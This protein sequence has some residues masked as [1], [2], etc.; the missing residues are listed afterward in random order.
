MTSKQLPVADQCPCC[1]S[2]NQSEQLASV[3]GTDKRPVWIKQRWEPVR[4]D[5]VLS[6]WYW[7]HGL[8]CVVFSLSCC[9]FDV[10][11][12]TF[13]RCDST[14]FVL[15][16]TNTVKP[17]YSCAKWH[18][19]LEEVFSSSTSI[20]LRK[21]WT[22]GKST[23]FLRILKVKYLNWSLHSVYFTIPSKVTLGL[24]RQR[25]IA[26]Q[27]LLIILELLMKSCIPKDVYLCLVPWR[28]RREVIKKFSEFK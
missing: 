23:N 26:S 13:R 14:Q 20:R 8:I 3:C 27:E 4:Q 1:S 15:S 12:F 17:L 11:W 28:D 2:A 10:F 24:K 6:W 7:K 5:Q 22:E 25:Q 18:L 9:M 21:Y 19:K 16:A